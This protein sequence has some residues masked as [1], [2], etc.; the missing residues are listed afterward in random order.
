MTSHFGSRLLGIASTLLL[1]GVPAVFGQNATQQPWTPPTATS[2][3]TRNVPAGEKMG[4]KGTIVD[5]DANVFTVRD[6]QGYITTV[7]IT[8]DTA[9]KTHGGLFRPSHHYDASVLTRGFYVEIEG[10][11]NASGQLEA[12][13]VH[14]DKD[15]FRTARSIE[16]RVTPAEN[17]LTAVEA[18]NR[19]LQGQ[20]DELEET[21]KIMRSDID[22]NTQAILT[23]DQRVTATNER[24]TAMDD[25]EVAQQ[26]TV[27]FKV[28]SAVLTDEAMAA[29]DQI[30]QQALTTKNY[31]IEVAGYTDTTGS[32]DKNRRLSQARAAAVMQYL[33]E[34]HNIPLR[35][36]M[37]PFGYGELNPAADN[38]TPE[39]RE[40]NRR[41]EVKVLTNKGLT[42]PAP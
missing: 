32:I 15:E 21:S 39:G 27:L 5:R 25:F 13:K 41:V 40:Q 33:G 30:A 19:A 42:Q 35:R 11:G 20:V 26:A 6:E 22:K 1:I 36:M 34:K 29:L 17:R 23:T 37:E 16:T 2:A 31:V 28:N 8:P 24:I 4:L 18:H 10:R 3:P 12:T 38:T 14:F 9:V 7:V